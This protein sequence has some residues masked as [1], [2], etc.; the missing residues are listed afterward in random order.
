MIVVKKSDLY[1]NKAALEKILGKYH[2]DLTNVF[3]YGFVCHQ[4][5]G[6]TQALNLLVKQ[7]ELEN[8]EALEQELSDLF[9]ENVSVDTLKTLSRRPVELKG[10]QFAI[11]EET[12]NIILNQCESLDQLIIKGE[13]DIKDAQKIKKNIEDQT[14]VLSGLSG[15]SLSDF[16]PEQINLFVELGDQYNHIMGKTPGIGNNIFSLLSTDQQAVVEY[17]KQWNIHQACIHQSHGI[18]VEILKVKPEIVNKPNAI[19]ENTPLHIAVFK[20]DEV[21]IRLLLSY[22]ADPDIKN[23]EGKTVNDIAKQ[24]DFLGKFQ[25]IQK[26]LS[27]SA[28]LS[29][30]FSKEDS[31]FVQGNSD[32]SNNTFTI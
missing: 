26:L 7:D 12:V 23:K 20:K 5:T 16:S 15:S 3:G 17:A 6:A 27:S 9:N 1:Q 2:L 18:L 10:I 31:A 13:Q 24:I 32:T 21:A 30:F 25:E 4:H 11:S 14:I 29:T 19:Y 22:G 28:T 8:R